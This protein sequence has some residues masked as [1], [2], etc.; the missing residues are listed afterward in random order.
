MGLNSPGSGVVEKRLK[1]LIIKPFHEIL[2][3]IRRHRPV[4]RKRSMAP[5]SRTS[6]SIGKH[7]GILVLV[8][9]VSLVV[10][11]RV[12]GK[13]I[14]IPHV[15]HDLHIKLIP[16]ANRLVGRDDLIVT[17]AVSPTFTCFLAEHADL[18]AVEINAS[19]AQ[20]H[21]SKG[22]LQIAVPEALRDVQIRLTLRYSAVFNDSYPEM[23]VNTDNP[24]Y[25]VT[26]IVS[27]TG[28]FLLAGSGW[29]PQTPSERA[30][31]RIQVDAPEGV[32]AVTAGRSM[33]RRTEGER[34]VSEWKI[35][36]AV[37]GLAL[38]AGRYLVTE[39]DLGDLSIATY[40]FEKTHPLADRYLNA[41][42]RYIR[43]YEELFGP[44]PFDKFAVVENFFPTGYGFPSYT[45]MG[46]RVLR[47]PFIIT[48]SLGHEIAHCWWGNGVLVAANGGNWSEGLTSYV[49]DYLYKERTSV[50]S[51]TE[52]RHQWLRN[53]A[54]LVDSSNDFPLAECR[55]RVDNPSKVVGYDKGAMVF[56]MIRQTIGDRAFWQALRDIY[57][58]KRFQKASWDDFRVAFERRGTCEG[59]P[60]RLNGFFNQWVLRKGAPQPT[61]GE[62]TRRQRPDGQWVV[63]GRVVQSSPAFEVR[64]N[65]V[66]NSADGNKAHTLLVQKGGARFE[67]VSPVK[68][69][70]LQ[71]DPGADVFRKLFPSEIP[72][73]VNSVKGADTVLMV[74]TEQAGPDAKDIAGLLARSLGLEN[75]G[76]IPE[77]GLNRRLMKDHDLVFIGLPKT[78]KLVSSI[79]APVKLEGAGFSAG[80]HRYTTSEDLLFAVFSHPVSDNRS[81]ALLFSPGGQLDVRTT[82]KLTHYGRYSYLGFRNGKNTDKGT[83]PVT[84]S[85]LIYSWKE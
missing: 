4:G 10:V 38:S 43:M 75:A 17:T 50:Q 73:S 78:Q 42:E 27:G 45:L 3:G 26:G 39:R 63:T 31:F 49:A 5:N 37:E 53:Y 64:L 77:A 62:V 44:Y 81:A 9:I 36:R 29:Y 14:S 80:D 54:T 85:P 56:H 32:I 12:F 69:M 66:L 72:E 79:P 28:T 47:L 23:P 1:R 2:S 18:T 25:G 20:Y 70:S 33:G 6:R 13:T 19:P 57:R 15:H 30:T 58:E 76:W 65:L 52:H 74:L 11:P 55:S 51:A 48:T 24:G 67:L 61:L 34:T 21:F 35:E 60:C 41:V 82:M 40:F 83:W 71:L 46:G 7:T 22:R 59:T 8:V 68:P 84:T 16:E